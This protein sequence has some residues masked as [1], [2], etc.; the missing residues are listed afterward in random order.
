M[1]RVI[2]IL[3]V[4]SMILAFAG[5]SANNNTTESSS[6]AEKAATQ[7]T[8]AGVNKKGKMELLEKRIRH[9]I[10]KEILEKYLIATEVESLG[11]ETKNIK[12]YKR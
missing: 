9:I 2:P 12:V 7:I 8:I 3:M 11:P 6:S 4:V 5:C 1:K 10:K